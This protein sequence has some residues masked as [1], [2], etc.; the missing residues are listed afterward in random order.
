MRERGIGV[1]METRDKG[2][3]RRTWQMGTNNNVRVPK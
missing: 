3:A 1:D 2:A